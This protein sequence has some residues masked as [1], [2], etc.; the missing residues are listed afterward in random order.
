MIKRCYRPNSTGFHK[1]GARGITVCERWRT[2]Q[3]FIADVGD[4]PT[5]QHTLE[6]R[7]NDGHYEPDNCYW[8]TY[9]EQA[10]NRRNSKRITINGVTRTA[11]QWADFLNQRNADYIYKRLRL[12]WNPQDAVLLPV[13]ITHKYKS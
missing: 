11:K 7:D 6:R 4:K 13:D 9:E 12:G 5:P 10:N 2:I 8:A 3:N 1:Y